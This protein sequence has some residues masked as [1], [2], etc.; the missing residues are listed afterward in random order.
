ML[1]SD[2]THNESQE[3][4]RARMQCNRYWVLIPC[5]GLLLFLI[6]GCSPMSKSECLYTDWFDYGLIDGWNGEPMSLFVRYSEACA[7][8]G[9]TPD[10]TEYEKGRTEGLKHYCKTDIGW[11][12]GSSGLQ[13]H[14]VC[15]SGL[16]ADFLKGY[17]PGRSLYDAETTLKSIEE[18]ITSGRE[19]ISE[20]ES[21]IEDLED[22]VEDE[23]TDEGDRKIYSRRLKEHERRI[24]NLDNRLDELRARRILAQAEYVKVV[25]K[26]E[27]LG[28]EVPLVRILDMR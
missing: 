27:G 13:Y 9:V 21:E 19:Q 1:C 8:H 24:K 28:F 2:N 11:E 3:D 25:S 17:E 5:L 23:E 10:R 6:Q 12:A 16:E 22:R 7:K 20:L 15:P 14:N 4:L 18:E 26:V